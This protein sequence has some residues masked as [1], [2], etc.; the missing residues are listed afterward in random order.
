VLTSFDP[1]PEATAFHKLS[2]TPSLPASGQTRWQT[3]IL[4]A[5]I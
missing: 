5:P 4:T 1:K 2:K 3:R